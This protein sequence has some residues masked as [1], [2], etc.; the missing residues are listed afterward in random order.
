[1]ATVGSG[2]ELQTFHVHEGVITPRSEY[3]KRALNKHWQT[4]EDKIVPLVR[5]DP[6]TFSLY[7]ELV[8]RGC[9]SLG[10]AGTMQDEDDAITVAQIYLL[11]ADIYILAD[12]LVDPST[13]NIVVDTM[14]AQARVNIGP[15]SNSGQYHLPGIEVIN[16]IYAKTVEGDGA[17]KLLIELH[18]ANK[19]KLAD[20]QKWKDISPE[21]MNELTKLR[22]ARG[23]KKLSSAGHFELTRYHDTPEDRA[24]RI[25]EDS[26]REDEDEEDSNED[27]DMEYEDREDEDYLD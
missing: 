15:Y 14:L 20:V 16:T 9:L 7:L 17:R 4:G 27:H 24:D 13:K 3:C 23:Y 18:D 11:L 21:F 5:E 26:E 6:Y 19:V 22:R 25:E 12:F 8:Y 10:Q 2:D 1:M